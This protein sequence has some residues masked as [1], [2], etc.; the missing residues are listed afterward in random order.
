MQ[1]KK[2]RTIYLDIILSRYFDNE[3][4]GMVVNSQRNKN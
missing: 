4:E 3:Y 2:A 1:N